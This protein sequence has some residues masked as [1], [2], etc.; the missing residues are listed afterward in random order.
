MLM[1]G[2]VKNAANLSDFYTFSII[3]LNGLNTYMY[4]HWFLHALTVLGALWS[5]AHCAKCMQG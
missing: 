2:A 3:E 1:R 5:K 4:K